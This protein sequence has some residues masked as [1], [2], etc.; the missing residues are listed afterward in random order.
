MMCHRKARRKLE[1]GTLP[2]DKVPAAAKRAFWR[3]VHFGFLDG[4]G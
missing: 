4:V 3:D 1:R 2:S